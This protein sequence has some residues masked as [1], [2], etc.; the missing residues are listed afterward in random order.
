MNPK[1]IAGVHEVDQVTSLAAQ[2]ATLTKQMA[3]MNS[4]RT[5]ASSSST[6]NNYD[7]ESGQPS[8]GS[9]FRSE[10]ANYVSNFNNSANNPF[11]QVYNP[12]WRNHPNFGWRQ[13]QGADQQMNRFPNAGL[14]GFAQPRQE[15]KPSTE[16]LVAQ[17]VHTQTTFIEAQNQKNKNIEASIHNLEVQVGQIAQAISARPMRTLSSNTENNPKRTKRG[18]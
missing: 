13:E 7:Y 17:L 16:D 14:P 18:C 1:K 15:R 5:Q 10:N 3:A 8:E 4:A 6:V 11:S 2:V 12:G 9:F